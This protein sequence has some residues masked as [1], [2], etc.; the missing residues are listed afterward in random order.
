MKNGKNPR[1]IKFILAEELVDFKNNVQL[2]KK[3]NV[4]LKVGCHSLEIA[5]EINNLLKI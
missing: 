5:L 2:N 3:P 1:D 4:D